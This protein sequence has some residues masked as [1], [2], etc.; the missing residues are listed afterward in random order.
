MMNS[1]ILALSL[2]MTQISP[3][4]KAAS[5]ST[6]PAGEV[7]SNPSAG[8]RIEV[9]STVPRADA[10]RKLMEASGNALLAGLNEPLAADEQVLVQV[11]G[12]QYD[13]RARVSAIRGGVVL[14][15]GEPIACQC[16]NTE[17]NERVDAE[18]GQAA[19]CLAEISQT[20][21]EPV[22]TEPQEP[23]GA[24]KPAF[25]ATMQ[26][27]SD[28]AS[29]SP[30]VPEW[31]PQQPVRQQTRRLKVAGVATLIAGS[32]V[33]LAGTGMLGIQS[34]ELSKN[35]HWPEY[36]RDWRL[37]GF[38]IGGAGLAAM[39]AGGSLMIV[40]EIRCRRRPASCTSGNR[41]AR[42]TLERILGAHL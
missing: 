30:A 27:R 31:R 22:V 13:Y 26:E 2:A 9:S 5:P 14:Y 28:H 4:A 20:H 10:L 39:I 36:E 34:T 42:R 17:L 3:T 21:D 29:P 12:E 8:L 41:H 23:V 7:A 19:E 38:A 35:N 11:E 6:L 32:A 33:L 40:D 24:T 16:S 18:I 37:P 15:D 25:V 1:S